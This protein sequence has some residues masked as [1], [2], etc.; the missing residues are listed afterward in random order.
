VDSLEGLE[1]KQRETMIVAGKKARPFCETHTA[2]T[3]EAKQKV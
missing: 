3:K 1:P 2:I